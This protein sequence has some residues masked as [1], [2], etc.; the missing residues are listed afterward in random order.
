MSFLLITGI[1][2]FA[3]VI[4]SLVLFTAAANAPM[5]WQAEAEVG[6]SLSCEEAYAYRAIDAYFYPERSF[7]GSL[8][9]FFSLLAPCNLL[10]FA[11]LTLVVGIAFRRSPYILRF[12]R[13]IWSLIG[14][15]V[16]VFVGVLVYTPLI[17]T[18]GCAVE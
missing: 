7:Q 8:L 18:I 9:Y 6:H 1:Y 16:A 2:L 13:I 15:G 14:I 5:V 3:L 17:S 12:N 11:V 10:G 4:F